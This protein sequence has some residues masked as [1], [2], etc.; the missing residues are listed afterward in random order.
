MQRTVRRPVDLAVVDQDLAR[1]ALIVQVDAFLRALVDFDLVG[2]HLL[3]G[4]PGRPRE[5]PYRR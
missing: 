2:G 1:P 3:R 4:S 5:L